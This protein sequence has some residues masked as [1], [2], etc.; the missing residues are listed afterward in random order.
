MTTPTQ[1]IKDNI[2][3]I[4][5]RLNLIEHQLAEFEKNKSECSVELQNIHSKIDKIKEDIRNHKDIPSILD[6]ISDVEKRIR[7]VELELPDL[8]LIKRIFLGFI[9][10]IL[11]AFIGALWNTVIQPPKKDDINDIAKKIIQEYKK[12]DEHTK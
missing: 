9:A 1:T 7:G 8:R 10:I 12:Q 2:N 11:S 4:L 6:S 5:S 3:S